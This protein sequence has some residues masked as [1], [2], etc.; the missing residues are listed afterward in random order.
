MGRLRGCVG[1]RYVFISFFFFFFFFFFSFYA[2]FAFATSSLKM[3]GRGKAEEKH[4][5]P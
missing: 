3:I 5:E 4:G 1:S 2:F